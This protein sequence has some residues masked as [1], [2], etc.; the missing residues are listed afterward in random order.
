MCDAYQ[1]IKISIFSFNIVIQ[2][3]LLSVS[4]RY[5][6]GQ[7]SKPC[8][9]HLSNFIPKSNYNKLVCITL[10]NFFYHFLTTTT[11]QDIYI[12]KFYKHLNFYFKYCDTV[13]YFCIVIFLAAIH[14]TS[15]ITHPYQIFNSLLPF[16]SVHPV[17]SYQYIQSLDSPKYSLN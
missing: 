5:I 6:S 9:S 10:I 1:Y 15:H 13:L 3:W 17:S 7:F 2:Y 16:M 12:R 8:F 4:L 14:N 11:K